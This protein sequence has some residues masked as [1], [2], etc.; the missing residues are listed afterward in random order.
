MCLSV[1]KPLTMR[2]SKRPLMRIKQKKQEEKK[3]DEAMIPL[4]AIVRIDKN[5]KIAEAYYHAYDK[6]TVKDGASYENWV[7]APHATYWSPYFGDEMIDL[8]THPIRV[9]D[10]A[11]MEALSYSVEFEDWGPVDFECFPAVDGVAW[12]THFG[13]HRK[14]DG[15]FMDFFAY[16][17][18]RT[19]E[20]GE[21]T[22]WETHVNSD[23]NDFLDVA[24]GEHGPY[25]ESS[26]DYMKAV[27][28]R[29]ASAG[30]D[31]TSMM[32]RG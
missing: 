3:M 9:D 2:L 21:I 18:V 5:R 22:H 8:E 13:G 14:S 24:I 10:A 4:N 32:H 28:K 29:L 30:I 6:K 23:Y 7:Y 11:T 19:N 17:F 27:M 31:V 15:V 20:A 26:D 16:S 1:G 25:R 12:K